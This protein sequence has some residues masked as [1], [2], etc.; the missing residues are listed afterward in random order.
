MKKCLALLLALILPLCLAACGNRAEPDSQTPA[1]PDLNQYFED[2]MTSLGE[3]V[4][5]MMDVEGDQLESTYP[6]LSGYETKQRVLKMAAI[7]SV[8]FEFALVELEKESDAQAV[9]GLFQSRIDS[10]IAG[11]AFYP[12]TIEA[13]EKAQV[14]T[15][16]SVVA[17]ICA[18]DEQA[19]AVDAF[20]A[21]FA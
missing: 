11:G 15:K 9:A 20:N 5:A 7:S 19:A 10:Q 18:S 14:V 1:A 6:G 21:L 17:L 3:N 13:W 12:M 4:P 2:F 16:G 8:P